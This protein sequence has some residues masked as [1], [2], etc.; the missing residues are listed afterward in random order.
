MI[1]KH[2]KDEKPKK[3]AQVLVF[4]YLETELGGKSGS[5][6]VGLVEWESE[7]TSVCWDTCYYHMEYQDI[8]H[9]CEIPKNPNEEAQDE[10]SS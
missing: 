10:A 8:T 4:G 9:W 7:K 3:G 5:P 6:N 1:W 2:I